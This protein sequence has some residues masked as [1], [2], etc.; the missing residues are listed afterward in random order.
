MSIET[1]EVLE[2]RLSPEI[3][4]AAGFALGLCGA[5]PLGM[6]IVFRNEGAPIWMG[7]VGIAFLFLSAVSFSFS[8]TVRIDKPNGQ[9]EYL[10]SCF[11]WNKKERQ[12][13]SEFTGVGI[14]MAGGSGAYGTS[15][16]YFVQLLGARN[17]NIPGMS[18]DK[19]AIISLAEQLG[20]SIGLPVEKEPRMVFFRSRL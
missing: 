10:S 12:A 13:I 7:V 17:L 19:A 11:L 15:T 3:P 16:K 2:F 8:K 9:V 14:G 4:R 20:A 1:A 5:V 6:S 18:I